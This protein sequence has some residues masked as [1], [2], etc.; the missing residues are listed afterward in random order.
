MRRALRCRK[1][2]VPIG[3]RKLDPQRSGCLSDA[4]HALGSQNRYDSGG[5]DEQEGQRHCCSGDTLSGG[6]RIEYME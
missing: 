5:M 3:S 6:K 4:R 1:D 2:C